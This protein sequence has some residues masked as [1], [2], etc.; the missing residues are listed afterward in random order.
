MF[1]AIPF[2]GACFL[3]RTGFP[4]TPHNAYTVLAD[5]ALII[6]LNYFAVINTSSCMTFLPVR[7]YHSLTCINTYT[8]KAPFMRRTF[9]TQTI[10]IHA[11]S[12][13]SAYLIPCT[14]ELETWRNTPPPVTNQHA[15]AQVIT[16]INYSVAILVHS[17]AYFL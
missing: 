16:V 14:S 10:L 3:R 13:R 11:Y 12:I 5:L 7:T 2:R 8:P 15:F 17:A 6:T 4:F 1:Y 9:N